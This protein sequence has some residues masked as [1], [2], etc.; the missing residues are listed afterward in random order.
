MS[1]IYKN[2]FYR[3]KTIQ[4]KIIGFGG[5]LLPSSGK[6][7]NLI[8]DFSSFQKKGR[9]APHLYN[10]CAILACRFLK[11]VIHKYYEQNLQELF[12]S[13]Q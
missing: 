3:H 2:F 9:K 5:K 4:N 12:P 8:A 6:T 10:V 13:S 11:M 7:T 1:S